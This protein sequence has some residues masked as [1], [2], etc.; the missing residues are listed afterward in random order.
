MLAKVNPHP[1]DSLIVFDE[2]P[3]IY[4]ITSDPD[5]AYTSCTT[6]I[7]KFFGHFDADAII[8]KMV[9]SRAW[10]KNKYHGKTREEIKMLWEI[11]RNEASLAGTA[12]HKA[13]EDF[14]NGE[15]TLEQLKPMPNLQH[16]L[17][18]YE[19]LGDKLSP[20]RSEWM[21]F[22][23]DY[24]LAGSIDFI[25]KNIDGSLDLWDWKRS[26]EIKRENPWQQGLRPVQHLP[27]TNYWHYSLQLNL[28]KTLLEKNYDVK[29]RN[30]SLVVMHPNQDSY[31]VIEVSDL[32][33]ELKLIL[34]HRVKQEK[35]SDLLL[36]P[37][38]SSNLTT[39]S[40][41]DGDGDN[42]S[43]LESEPET[44]SNKTKHILKLSYSNTD[45]NPSPS[46]NII[47]PPAICLI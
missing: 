4:T 25:T 29:V 3:H 46:A 31:E 20:Y 39:C 6:F 36:M 1:R 44:E 2:E 8:D 11:N 24:K 14:Y 13:I 33:R 38:T 30:L 45:V 28:Y 42:D 15:L 5:S 19:E 27:D 43:N 10:S 35:F 22:D 41:G 23:T 7:H 32:T 18:F 34:N 40:D 9:N 47:K 12:M 21:I 37:L 17:K 26:R 16:F